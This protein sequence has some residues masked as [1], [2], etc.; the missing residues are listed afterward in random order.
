[1]SRAKSI[2]KGVD[3]VPHEKFRARW[4]AYVEDEES[5]TVRIGADDSLDMRI[6]GP[7]GVAT[8]KLY[9]TELVV[10][11]VRPEGVVRVW[12][13]RVRLALLLVNGDFDRAKQLP[14]E[15]D[16]IVGQAA[17]VDTLS[18]WLEATFRAFKEAS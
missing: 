8:V 5:R 14:L 11:G 17:T 3:F 7:A 16:D 13:E 18:G 15:S 4:V 9:G 6:R 1:M 2:A 10:R 12:A